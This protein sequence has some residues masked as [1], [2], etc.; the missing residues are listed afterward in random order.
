MPLLTPE[1]ACAELGIGEDTLRALRKAGEIPYV[2]IGQGKK[3]ETPRYELDDLN[4]WKAKRKKVASCPSIEGPIPR[5]A[6]IRT[7][8]SYRV[9][10]FQ[11]QRAARQSEKR[12]K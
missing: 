6:S 4:A 1:Q 12:N 7:T 5:T 11:A 9:V 2:N 8:S 3:R 10:D